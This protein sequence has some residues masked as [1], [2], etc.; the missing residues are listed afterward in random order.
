MHDPI[1]AIFARHSSVAYA[2]SA[3]PNAPVV[4]EQH[5]IRRG[6]IRRLVMPRGR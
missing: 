5:T 3:R 6:R 1:S 2:Q 4:C